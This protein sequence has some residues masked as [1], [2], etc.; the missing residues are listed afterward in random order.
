MTGKIQTSFNQALVKEI[1]MSAV[2]LKRCECG[3]PQFGWEKCPTCDRPAVK[4]E[5]G[6]VA[7]YHKNPL[8][9]LLFWARKK[10]GR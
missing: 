2:I 10:L 1:K 4:V 3:Q 5:Q 7:Y 8:R 6:V 9:R